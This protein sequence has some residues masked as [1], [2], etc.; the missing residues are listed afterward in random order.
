MVKSFTNQ[1]H[2]ESTEYKERLEDTVISNK[3]DK[4]VTA[5]KRD[6]KY[7]F[8]VIH[9]HHR[10]S[11]QWHSVYDE[12]IHNGKCNLGDNAW[13]PLLSK[14]IHKHQSALCCVEK[15]PLVSK[16][17]SKQY[18][19]LRNELIGIRHIL[20]LIA[21]TDNS[22]LCTEFRCTYRITG[23]ETVE[24]VTEQHIQFYH[25][26]RSLF[27]AVELFGQQMDSK[28][29]VFHGLSKKMNFN[30]F[31]AYRL[32]LHEYLAAMTVSY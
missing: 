17:F 4:Y 24:Q 15:D 27:E 1:N 28:L 26:A 16:Y 20:A 6:P 7:G 32:N 30:K 13:H 31:T 10:L 19:I 18:H 21:Y 11:P 3:N 8:G 2:I 29:V 25:L 5:I 12:M 23:A 22:T 9:E 14:A